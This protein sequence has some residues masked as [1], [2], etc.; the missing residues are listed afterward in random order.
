MS[1]ETILI[2]HSLDNDL[3]ALK[4]IHRRCVDTCVMY[5]HPRGF[6]FRQSL[7]YITKK[8]L[9]KDIQSYKSSKQI[10]KL[11]TAAEKGSESKIGDAEAISPPVQ[12]GHDSVE[13]AHAALMLAVLKVNC[14]EFLP[15]TESSDIDNR[16][17][18]CDHLFT[19]LKAL[20]IGKSIRSNFLI[21]EHHIS[22]K[23]WVGSRSHVKVLE[24][25]TNLSL[26]SDKMQ[27]FIQ[28]SMKENL[29]IRAI[30]FLGFSMSGGATLQNLSSLS[31]LS[32]NGS[33]LLV[34]TAQTDLTNV[35]NLSVRKRSLSKKSGSMCVTTWSDKLEAELKSEQKRANIG[36]CILR[37]I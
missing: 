33:I 22:N 15:I 35:K 10:V 29:D 30:G 16:V 13:D 19:E 31:E 32:G 26:A 12:Q 6:P 2:G 37:V 18:L 34:V 36:R 21:E 8:Y 27:T 5:P 14:G 1:A 9:D 28:C 17:S 24:P 20:D 4:I 25:S 7:K 11:E 3:R 23:I